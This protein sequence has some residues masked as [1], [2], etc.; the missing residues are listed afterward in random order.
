MKAAKHKKSYR[1]L[2]L[3]ESF[4]PAYYAELEAVAREKSVSVAGVL[5]QAVCLPDRVPLFR[6]KT[7]P[8][9]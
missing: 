9:G 2:R 7:E 1:A 4:E 3:S 6:P 5:P 8:T